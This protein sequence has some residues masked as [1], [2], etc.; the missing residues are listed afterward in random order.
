MIKQLI[1]MNE[2]LNQIGWLIVCTNI[3]IA[4]ELWK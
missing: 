1:I 4:I 2:Y 3:L